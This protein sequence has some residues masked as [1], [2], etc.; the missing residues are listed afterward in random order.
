MEM[1]TVAVNNV[2]RTCTHDQLVAK[3]EDAGFGGKFGLVYMPIDLRK[4]CATGQ[5]VIDF[6]SVEAREEFTNVFHRA[7][8]KDLASSS[9]A[10]AKLLEVSPA[11]TQ[12]LSANLEKLRSSSLLMD[13]LAVTPA[14]LPRLF[15]TEGVPVE[16]SILL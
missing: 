1:T 13:L 12:G 9:P 10:G 5:A 2:P 7:S 16:F 11:P 3:L 4:K 8:A 14:W 15:D 6:H